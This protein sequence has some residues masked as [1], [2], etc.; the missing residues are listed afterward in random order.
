MRYSKTKQ[1]KTR[2]KILNAAVVALRRDGVD[3]IGLS[4]LMA[5][6]GLTKGGFYAHFGSKDGPIAEAV[7]ASL[8]ATGRRFCETAAQPAADGASGLLAIIDAYLGTAHA[9]SRETGC[10]LGALLSDRAR[11]GRGADCRGRWR[12]RTCVGDRGRA[13]TLRQIGPPADRSGDP[14]GPHGMPALGAPRNR[15]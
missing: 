5:E 3:G 13:A 14:R 9:N 7:G 10:K 1:A 6:A 12:R 4:G 15:D 11:A 2:A 8:S